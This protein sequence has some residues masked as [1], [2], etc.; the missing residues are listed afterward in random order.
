MGEFIDYQA[1]EEEH[2]KASKLKIPF[3]NINILVTLFIVG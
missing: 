2:E 1:R 3:K